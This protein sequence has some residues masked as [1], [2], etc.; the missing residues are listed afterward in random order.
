MEKTKII[1]RDINK[2]NIT[3][4]PKSKSESFEDFYNQTISKIN[5]DEIYNSNVNPFISAS[6]PLFEALSEIGDDAEGVDVDKIRSEFISRINIFND[7]CINNRIENMEILVSRYILCTFIDEK[8]NEK[9]SE[10]DDWF[11]K[12][13]LSIFHNETYGGENFF[14]LLEKFLK[15]PAK[16]I[17]IL[18]LMYICLSLGFLGRY[19]VIN[20]GVMEINSIRDSLYRQIKIIQRR[21][22]LTFYKKVEPSKQRFELFSKVSY[23]LVISLVSILLILIYLFLSFKL[24]EKS[25]EVSKELINLSIH[26]IEN[27]SKEH[28]S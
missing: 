9:L 11:N 27:I 14:H 20:K 7:K 1:T 2:S 25:D 17:N 12:S 8:L 10:T 23:S 22:P 6:I 15:T 19:R 5:Y 26:K 18:E 4:F 24:S 13:L 3:N 16:Y 21:E 28:I